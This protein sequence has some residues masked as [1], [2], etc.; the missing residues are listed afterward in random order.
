MET[1]RA[2]AEAVAG[3][4]ASAGEATAQA[5]LLGEAIRMGA[6]TEVPTAQDTQAAG[7][8]AIRGESQ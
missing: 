7:V 3:V 1:G 2:A 4:R 8:V 6:M 5:H